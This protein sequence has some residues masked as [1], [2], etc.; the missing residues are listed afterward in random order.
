MPR[1]RPRARLGPRG[2]WLRGPRTAAMLAA[3]TVMAT[4]SGLLIW[5]Q[6]PALLPGWRSSVVVTG[7]MAPRIVPGD[8]VLFQER[9]AHA[10]RPGTVVLFRHPD[11]PERLLSHRVHEVREDGQV[12]TAGDANARPDAAPVHP[13]D[14]LGHGRLRVPWIGMPEV[15]WLRGERH[16]LVLTALAF[17]AA[18]ALAVP[19]RAFGSHAS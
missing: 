11:H 7:S 12:I 2:S 17:L 10:V 15:W 16:H 18:A 8:V 3:R 14:I 13:R 9:P 4:L 5:S 6:A 1:T 19:W